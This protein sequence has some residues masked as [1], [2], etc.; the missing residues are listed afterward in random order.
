LRDSAHIVKLDIVTFFVRW[1]AGV[2]KGVEHFNKDGMN[3]WAEE[4]LKKLPIQL[5]P[6]K[7]KPTTIE[8]KIE[9]IRRM[10]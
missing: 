4:D 8:E 5:K 2:Y 3:Y 1:K 6:K 9:K 7:K 10:R